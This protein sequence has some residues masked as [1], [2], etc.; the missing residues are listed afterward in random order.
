MKRFCTALLLAFG[1]AGCAA[2]RALVKP[3][4]Y[5]SVRIQGNANLSRE[6]L[7]GFAI[8]HVTDYL[9]RDVGKSA[10]DD[11][12]YQIE[13]Y[14]K[15]QGFY[16]ALVDYEIGGADGRDVLFLVDE[17]PRI[18]LTELVL[19][20]GEELDRGHLWALAEGIAGAPGTAPFVRRS[21]DAAAAAVAAEVRLQGYA[22]ASVAVEESE[23][24]RE[25]RSGRARLV[26]E[27]GLRL[28]LENVLVRGEGVPEEIAREARS[29]LGEPYEP[30][31]VA[32][33]LARI[34]ER[35]RDAGYP[36][37]EARIDETAVHD[38]G[39]E[40]TV[41]ATTGERVTLSEVRFEGE[42][43]TRM[44]FLEELVDLR[45]GERY[46]AAR[47]R[48]AFERLYA[49]GLFEVVR[50]RLEPPYGPERVLIWE[51]TE[52]PSLE[53]W[54]EPGYGSYDG[55]RARA[56]VREHNLF[57][58][59]WVL[60]SEGTLSDKT[61]RAE[62]G[63]TDP[64]FFG[65]SLQLDVAVQYSRREEPSFQFEEGAVETSLR[66]RWSERFST[67]L[68]YR[69]KRSNLLGEDLQLLDPEDVPTDFDVSAIK[70]SAVNDTRD[71]FLA[72]R[73]GTRAEASLEWADAA[74]GSQIDFLRG[75]ASLGTF[76]E[77]RPGT[78]LALRGAA[79]SV[80]PLHDTL[81][82][83]LQERYFLG[84]EASVRSFQ[85]S[86]L[87]PKDAAGEPLGGEAYTLF[88][89][90]LRQALV[91]NFGLVL[92][93]DTG[94]VVPDYP[95]LFSGSDYSHALGMGLRYELPV[96]SLRFDVGWNPDPEP[97]DDDYA[98]HFSIGQAF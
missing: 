17:G 84:G 32:T 7:L 83:P 12:A 60:R 86:Q 93:G 30:R 51:L 72:P 10:V 66:R 20:G 2:S 14:Y 43:S 65:T 41:L 35:L 29:G 21:L 59:G 33:V 69:F 38:G 24:D 52:L 67:A 44:S 89:I 75:T 13:L 94:S 6:E 90:E 37:A 34:E 87:G 91:K 61:R 92:F 39:V 98:L 85:E 5:P 48:D 42:L 80:V 74:L 82:I 36:D 15:E 76:Q 40:L 47:V 22:F 25:R 16:Y 54:V 88:S 77:L 70:L 95:D 3:G 63:V 53:L 62:V 19:V 58:R 96:G 18:V 73:T 55:L 46:S 8:D 1:L 4:E 49:T 64:R 26:I 81:E 23:P 68:G 71:N 27:P 78:V 28:S 79:G 50:H 57:G 9:E 45:A 31:L 56:G 11:A 97:E